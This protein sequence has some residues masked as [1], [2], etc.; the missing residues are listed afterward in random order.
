MLKTG[1]GAPAGLLIYNDTQLPAFYRGWLYYP[2]VFRKLI[3]AYKVEPS[4]STF[5]AVS[6]F[7]FLRSDDP[8]FR[9]C[10][11]LTGPDGAIYIADWRTDSGGAGRLFG[12][13]QHGRIYR[14]TWAG[15]DVPGA[16]KETPAIER[17]AMN[18]W[19]EVLKKTDA[20]LLGLLGSED[21]TIRD[22]VRSELVR[23]GE[24][25]RVALSELVADKDAP[26]PCSADGAGNRS[27]AVE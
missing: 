9:P 7:E 10:Q 18:S 5:K 17:R 4:F 23:R 12:D 2:D 20:E 19:A 21:S 6:E 27:N 8:L 24:K 22:V 1:R 11:M 13:G 15:G 14:V 25:N 16:E 3:R 26:N